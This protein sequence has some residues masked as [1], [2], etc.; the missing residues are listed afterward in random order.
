M[1]YC[2]KS[3][4]ISL[5][6]LNP[7]PV[8]RRFKIESMIDAKEIRI[9]T[10]MTKNL[11][12]QLQLCVATGTPQNIFA[13]QP[14]SF[15]TFCPHLCDKDSD[16]RSKKRPLPD[17]DPKNEDTGKRTATVRGSI[18]NTTGK[19]IYLPRGLKNRYCSDFLDT[20]SSCR[21]GDKCTFVHTVY[22]TNVPE[23]D[24]KIIDKFVEETEGLSFVDKKPEKKVS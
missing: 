1:F 13:Q 21:H 7:A 12:D 14:S 16:P 9:A 3:L 23:E 8:I 15:K 5:S 2:I 18:I 22:P 4:I 19:K 6:L 11:L 24:R 20:N 17:K 10:I